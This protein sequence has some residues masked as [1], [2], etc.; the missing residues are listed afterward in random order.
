MKPSCVCFNNYFQEGVGG[1]STNCANTLRDLLY[2]E[3]PTCGTFD[4]AFDNHGTQIA[5]ESEI[6]IDLGYERVSQKTH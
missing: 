3:A 1:I 4:G 6:M 5:L 2:G